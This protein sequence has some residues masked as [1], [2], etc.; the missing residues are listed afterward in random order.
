MNKNIGILGCGWLGKPLGESLV[1]KG[2]KVR[3]S[4]TR[5]ENISSLRRAG[6]EGYQLLI[7]ENGI[8]GPIGSFLQGLQCLVLNI[9]P[10]L[11]SNPDS[12]FAAK[13]NQLRIALGDTVPH[14]IFVSSISVYGQSQGIV[15]EKDV[16]KPE[17]ESGRQLLKAESLLL[18]D[19]KR[20][21]QVV[22][23]GGL[24]GP[25]RH[26]VRMLSGK[27]FHDGGNQKVNLIRLEDLLLALESLISG[28]F[29]SGIYNAVYP[30]HPTKRDFYRR[31]AQFFKVQPPGYLHPASPAKGKEVVSLAFNERGIR[32]TSPIYSVK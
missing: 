14:V 5:S 3:G 23:P 22:R 27:Q 25:D 8:E 24:L 13:T 4:S 1:K 32:F 16:P 17:S 15:S 21:I 7:T 6:I 11:R 12:D 31:E 30:D 26:P 9:P 10:G 2:Y 28:S 20:L 18:S 29:P 19:Q